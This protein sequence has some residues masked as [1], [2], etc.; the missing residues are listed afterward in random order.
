MPRCYFSCNILVYAAAF[1]A[2]KSNSFFQSDKGE[3]KQLEAEHLDEYE[4]GKESGCQYKSSNLSQDGGREIIHEGK[5][6]RLVHPAQER[7]NASAPLRR[8]DGAVYSPSKAGTQQDSTSSTHALEKPRGAHPG[9]EKELAGGLVSPVLLDHFP[10]DKDKESTRGTQTGRRLRHHRDPK[11]HNSRHRRMHYRNDAN[12]S[13]DRRHHQHPRR[14]MGRSPSSRDEGVHVQT[15]YE[16]GSN[17]NRYRY[18][19]NS[20]NETEFDAYSYTIILTDGEISCTVKRQINDI[21]M[22]LTNPS[23]IIML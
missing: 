16:N 20:D 21:H 6:F 2:F 23:H 15:I 13:S 5:V 12:R 17:S 18:S 8:L 4:G 7:Q 11:W 3:T 10:T 19:S 9:K 1:I 22:I 14:H